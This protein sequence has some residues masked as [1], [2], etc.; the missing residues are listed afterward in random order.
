MKSRDPHDLIDALGP[1][2]RFLATRFLEGLVDWE[3]QARRAKG[4][5]EPELMDP[6]LL[7]IVKHF[8]ELG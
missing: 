6:K 7:E 2:G 3:R 4:E 8:R 5:P 1:Q